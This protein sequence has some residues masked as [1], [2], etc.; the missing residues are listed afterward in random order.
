MT[1]HAHAA[2]WRK[3]LGHLAGK[4]DVRGCEIGVFKGESAEWM[5]ENIFTHETARYYC[6]D[7]WAGGT[8]HVRDGVD[9]MQVRMEAMERLAPL[10]QR[11]VIYQAES[12]GFLSKIETGYFD[13][14]YI[15]GA[16]DAQNVLRD[17][18]LGWEC[19]KVGGVMIFDD[20][21]WEDMPDALDR[22]RRAIDA[23]WNCYQR[24][25]QMLSVC[26]EWQVALKK[27]V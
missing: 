12:H 26:N 11:A 3:W 20:Y 15:D 9:M 16:H 10:M 19:L 25:A 4:P 22:P 6:V 2:N 24:Q 17:A 13:F 1:D 27:I 7:T 5:L 21:L 8:E 18:V 14:I 23:F